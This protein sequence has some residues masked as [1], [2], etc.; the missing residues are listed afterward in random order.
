MGIKGLQGYYSIYI[1][2]YTSDDAGHRG[3]SLSERL[4]RAIV[5]LVAC[6]VEMCMIMMM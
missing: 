4:Y 3:V 1:C 2:R 5:V 6:D